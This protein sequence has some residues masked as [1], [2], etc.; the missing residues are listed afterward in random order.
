MAVNATYLLVQP[1]GRKPREA[2]VLSEHHTVEDAFAELDRLSEVAGRFGLVLHE[3][4]DVR[5]VECERFVPVERPRR[6]VQ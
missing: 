6:H 5:V 2:T 3:C 1:Y 4:I